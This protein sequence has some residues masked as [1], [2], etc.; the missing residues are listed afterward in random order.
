[1]DMPSYDE[2]DYGSVSQADGKG[3]G[4]TYT[5][6]RS[7]GKKL[8]F[9]VGAGGVINHIARGGQAEGFP[10]LT[11]GRKITRINSK[12]VS[13]LTKGEIVAIIKE[14]DAVQLVLEDT[15]G[16]HNSGYTIMKAPGDAA[17][18]PG[19]EY[20]VMFDEFSAGDTAYDY[21]YHEVLE[22][23]ARANVK[24]NAKRAGSGGGGTSN[25]HDRDHDHEYDHHEVLDRGGGPGESYGTLQD[26][27]GGKAA[28]GKSATLT[29][30]HSISGADIYGVPLAD[31][32]QVGKKQSSAAS[33][34]LI[35]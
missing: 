23:T 7:G 35:G 17:S 18:V 11:A 10:A 16:T 13:S 14:Q 1:M 20:D 12:D 26:F 21:D 5:L 32:G 24:P 34:H 4:N 9:G 15:L 28:G 19:G 22:R 27:H 2:I 8:G 29:S 3:N 6:D 30:H 31:G 25:E 33:H